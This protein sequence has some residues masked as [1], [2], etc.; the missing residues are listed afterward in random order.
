MAD[1]VLAILNV[2]ELLEKILFDVDIRTLLLSQ[3][4]NKMFKATIDGSHALQEAL[5]FEAEAPADTATPF[6]RGDNLTFNPL[7]RSVQIVFDS[8]GSYIS[9]DLS[10]EQRTAVSVLL[11]SSSLKGG[12]EAMVARVMIQ[13]QWCTGAGNGCR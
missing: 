5:F 6:K 4:V 2:V 3:R 8:N 9:P 1:P 13:R 12:S 7:F 11:H 10:L